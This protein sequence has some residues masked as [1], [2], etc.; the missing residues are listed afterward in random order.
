MSDQYNLEYFVEYEPVGTNAP[1]EQTAYVHLRLDLPAYQD[2]LNKEQYFATTTAAQS[3]DEIVLGSGGATKT[4]VLAQSEV[5]VGTLFGKIY[6]QLGGSPVP[7][8]DTVIQTFNTTWPGVMNFTLV[9]SPSEFVQSGTVNV[10]SNTATLV[11]NTTPSNT[12]YMQA[13]YDYG[14]GTSGS[15][16]AFITGL[17]N[18]PGVVELAVTAYR[19]WAM[20][21]IT[22][23]WADILPNIIEYLRINLDQDGVIELS[24]SGRVVQTGQRRSTYAKVPR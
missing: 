16:A 17:F 20:K 15:G 4:Y 7:G 6:H 14:I 12:Y 11:W 13:N 18:I 22:Y 23:D 2:Q 24:G 10:I 3:T 9:G 19:V 8:T 5:Y 1:A 21:G